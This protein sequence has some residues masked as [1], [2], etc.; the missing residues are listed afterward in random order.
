MKNLFKKY[1]QSVL[2]PNEFDTFADFINWKKNEPEIHR[3]MD[4]EWRRQSQEIFSGEQNPL[5][6]QKIKQRILNEEL[7]HSLQRTKYYSIALK[8]AAALVVGLVIANVWMYRGQ[9]LGDEKQLVQKVSVPNGAKTEFELPDGSKVWLN[10]GSTIS[11]AANFNRNRA[12][13]LR[14]E[15]F[16]DVAKSKNTF[17]VETKSGSVEVLGTAFNV[18]AYE[19][20]EFVTTLERGR[21]EILNVKGTRLGTL[22]PGNQVQLI[23]NQ[24]VK[25]QVDTQI[26]TSWKDGK[27]IFVRETFPE[28][29]R[30]LER[31]FNVDIQYSRADFEGLWFSGTIENET[32]SEVMD[33]ICK[34][35]SVTYY[36]NSKERMIKV[37]ALKK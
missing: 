18:Q 24:F 23:D 31:W 2:T 10:G 14:G 20:G 7:S 19:E 22:E 9:E 15:A 17:S 26:Y 16:F 29:M 6:L 13:E 21:V 32:I 1:F 35:A 4:D 25:G 5:L 11:Y 33:I 30:R 27:L 28:T 12:V 36:Y 37:N 3:F 8:I 34:V